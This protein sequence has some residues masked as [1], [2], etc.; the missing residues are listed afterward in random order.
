MKNDGRPLCY[1][2][3]RNVALLLGPQIFNQSK[4][5]IKVKYRADVI[6]KSE[7]G[8]MN[9]IR[10]WPHG[11]LIVLGFAVI[12]AIGAALWVKYERTAQ[13]KNLPNAARID[14]VHVQ[15]GVN[16]S[17]DNIASNDWI[18]ATQNTPIS[19]G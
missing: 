2:L 11:A 14:R 16:H 17:L 12:A 6:R 3:R 7:V 10:I 8:F 4:V 19:V 9:R 18:E 13:A 15:V 5:S 1:I